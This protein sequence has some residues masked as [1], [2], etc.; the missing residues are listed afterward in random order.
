RRRLRRRL[1]GRAHGGEHR[2]ARQPAH[3]P[4]G[5]GLQPRQAAL[6]RPVQQARP[7][8]RSAAGGAAAAPQ[9][10]AGRR[11]SGSCVLRRGCLRHPEGGREARLDGAQA[12]RMMEH[13]QSEDTMTRPRFRND[14]VAQ[15]IEEEG[16]RYV[17]VTD[18][19]SGSTF[20]FYDVEYSIACAMDGARAAATLAD[21]PRAELGIEA[22]PDELV[23]VINTLAELGYLEGV[24]PAA[25]GVPEP[26]GEVTTEVTEH[27]GNGQSA[28]L[29]AEVYEQAAE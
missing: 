5:A 7:G 8:Q 1:A 9:P 25:S 23:S 11:I 20:R 21:G 18:P 10:H 24:S 22:W 4:A 15:P 6:R 3:E 13:T 14:L 17:D 29:M 26:V 2:V 28:E 12:R 27:G 16:V 19:N